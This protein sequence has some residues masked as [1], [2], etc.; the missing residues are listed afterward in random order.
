MSHKVLIG[1][2]KILICLPF[3]RKY[4]ISIIGTAVNIYILRDIVFDRVANANYCFTHTVILSLI[5]HLQ[6]VR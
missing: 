2:N 5:Q 1:P 6:R 3:L 4:V